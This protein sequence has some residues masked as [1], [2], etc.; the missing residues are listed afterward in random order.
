MQTKALRGRIARVTRKYPDIVRHVLYGDATTPE[1]V[2]RLAEF[3]AVY[4]DLEWHLDDLKETIPALLVDGFRH[5]GDEVSERL[6]AAAAETKFANM[7]WYLQ[8]GE[9]SREAVLIWVVTLS[10]VP[11]GNV[12]FGVEHALEGLGGIALRTSNQSL[13][14]VLPAATYDFLIATGCDVLPSA[15]FLRIAARVSARVSSQMRIAVRL[16]IGLSGQPPDFSFLLTEWFGK[17]RFPEM[18][19]QFSGAEWESHAKVLKRRESAIAKE[20]ERSFSWIRAVLNK[21]TA[22]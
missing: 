10:L 13:V 11:P 17:D 19:Q 1:I 16:N 18:W 8:T 4:P 5:P 12:A 3:A 21:E 15:V 14:A 9:D 20:W 7:E 2:H 22:G 6:E